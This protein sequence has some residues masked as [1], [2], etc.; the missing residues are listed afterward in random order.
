MIK[1]LLSE[2]D[3]ISWNSLKKKKYNSDVNKVRCKK[4]D[5]QFVFPNFKIEA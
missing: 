5:R 4:C 1:K 3:V 2:V